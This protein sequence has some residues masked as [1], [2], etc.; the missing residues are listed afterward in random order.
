MED[1]STYKVTGITSTAGLEQSRS[2]MVTVTLTNAIEMNF[3]FNAGTFSAWAV[4]HSGNDCFSQDCQ[5]GGTSR[6]PANYP[7]EWTQ[8]VCV[9][10]TACLETLRRAQ[11]LP[12]MLADIFSPIA[13]CWPQSDHELAWSP[14]PLRQSMLHVSYIRYL[15]NLKVF[16]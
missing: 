5:S 10:L 6:E 7:T 11:G 2:G 13:F 12:T 3:A 4:K 1:F 14:M 8:P 9:Y 15:E 16:R